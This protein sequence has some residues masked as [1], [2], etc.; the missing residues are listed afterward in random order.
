MIEVGTGT[1]DLSEPQLISKVREQMGL[2]ASSVDPSM[3][4]QPICQK[5]TVAPSTGT[6]GQKV[7]DQDPSLKSMQAGV[8]VTTTLGQE[9]R[10]PIPMQPFST[11]TQND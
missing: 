7:T 9:G 2:G 5:V 10:I 4:G 6:T 3:R 8:G 1:Q 11:K